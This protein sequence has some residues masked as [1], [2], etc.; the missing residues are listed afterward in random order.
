[1]EAL[2]DNKVDA[3]VHDMRSLTAMRCDHLDKAIQA[4]RGDLRKEL[5]EVTIPMVANYV[6]LEH[7]KK[8]QHGL[9]SPGFQIGTIGG[10]KLGSLRDTGGR[11]IGESWGGAGSPA[12]R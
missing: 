1:M 10:P 3:A 9:N 11:T 4:V 8:G 7:A 5:E 2:A 12:F 6:L